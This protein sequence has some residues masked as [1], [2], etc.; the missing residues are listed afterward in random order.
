MQLKLWYQCSAAQMEFA[1]FQVPG[2]CVLP[3]NSCLM[4]V[5]QIRKHLLQSLSL[6][7]VGRMINQRVEPIGLPSPKYSTFVMIHSLCQ[8]SRVML[9]E[10]QS[11]SLW[12]ANNHHEVPAT[13]SLNFQSH[14]RLK[15]WLSSFSRVS[16]LLWFRHCQRRHSIHGCSVLSLWTCKWCRLAHRVFALLPKLAKL[17]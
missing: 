9:P 2:E 17:G 15:W 7:Q 10:F 3:L 1:S 16:V 6:R 11:S 13:R 12:S 8:P 5:K 4:E 14:S